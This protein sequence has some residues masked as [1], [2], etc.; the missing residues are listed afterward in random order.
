MNS[1]VIKVIKGVLVVIGVA[2]AIYFVT[3]FFTGKKIQED[4]PKQVVMQKE[5]DTSKQMVTK[6]VVIKEAQ[7]V[8]SYEMGSKENVKK[9][10][11]FEIKTEIKKEVDTTSTLYAVVGTSGHP[12]SGSVSIIKIENS[13]YIRYENFK[14]I[15]G[16]DLFVYLSKDLKAKDFINL[17]KLKATEGNINYEIPQAVN[18]ADYP[19]VI[20]WCED[21]SIL[22]NYAKLGN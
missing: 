5:E 21:F 18:V 8:V 15:N 11:A 12:A 13:Q 9:T 19:Y 6:E 1:T 22:F 3:P 10:E 4:I 14:T 2:V 17:G 7:K 16:P 20:V